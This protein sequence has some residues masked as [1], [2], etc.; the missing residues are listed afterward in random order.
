MCYQSKSGIY[1]FYSPAASTQAYRRACHCVMA[2]STSLCDQDNPTPTQCT[3]EVPQHPWLLSWKLACKNSQFY[4][5][6][7]NWDL[8]VER[9]QARRD[10]VWRLLTACPWGG[11]WSGW[12]MNWG[13]CCIS[14]SRSCIQHLIV[15]I[16]SIDFIRGSTSCTVVWPSAD[17]LTCWMLHGHATDGMVEYLS[18]K[19]RLEHTGGH[20][21]VGRQCNTEQLLVSEPNKVHQ[22]RWITFQ[23]M[24]TSFVAWRLVA[25]GQFFG[26]A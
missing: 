16:L 6:L 10:K 11:A 21:G 14:G 15:V 18:S 3:V 22:W 1:N 25:H 13:N 8:A 19:F 17:R 5:H 2:S 24:L 12:Q 26:V 7:C 4:N 23:Q 9:P 20:L